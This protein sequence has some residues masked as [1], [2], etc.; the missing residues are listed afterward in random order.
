MEIAIAEMNKTEPGTMTSNEE[1]YEQALLCHT[2]T[3]FKVFCGPRHG[4][5]IFGDRCKIQGYDDGLPMVPTEKCPNDEEYE[6]FL[7]LEYPHVKT[8]NDAFVKEVFKNELAG[9]DTND[10]FSGVE[11]KGVKAGCRKKDEK[12]AE[13]APLINPIEYTQFRVSLFIFLFVK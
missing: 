12:T 7:E 11:V 9:V 6:C 5:T 1:S 3:D 13:G 8:D 10:D 2:G 4:P